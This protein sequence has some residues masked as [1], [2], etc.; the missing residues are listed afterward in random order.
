MSTCQWLQIRCTFSCANIIR[1]VTSGLRSER[2]RII[3]GH[4]HHRHFFALLHALPCAFFSLH[5]FTTMNALS[6]AIFSLHNFFLARKW[7]DPKRYWFQARVSV[8]GPGSVPRSKGTD[9]SYPRQ[10]QPQEISDYQVVSLKK[11]ILFFAINTC[12]CLA[13]HFWESSRDKKAT[14]FDTYV[15]FSRLSGGEKAIFLA[16]V[17]S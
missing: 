4:M 12:R 2:S 14:H 3:D 6:C 8:P 16:S 10:I 9:P 1:E 13:L 5:Y 17:Y 15:G 11:F 7:L